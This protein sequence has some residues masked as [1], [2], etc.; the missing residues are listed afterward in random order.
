MKFSVMKVADSRIDE[1]TTTTLK[2]QTEAAGDFDIEWGKAT[3]HEP[4]MQT[5]LND[6]RKWLITNNFDPEDPSL[7]IGHPKI[8]QVDLENSFGSTDFHS[9][10]KCT[11][12]IP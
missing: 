10:S 2:P 9:G 1:L 5:K 8:G 6:F 3:L 4:F 11:N 7:T 12:H